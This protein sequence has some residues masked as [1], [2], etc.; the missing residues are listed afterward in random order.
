MMSLK[1]KLTIYIYNKQNK[2]DEERGELNYR[3]RNRPVDD[4]EL[5]EILRDKMR[6]EIWDE[7]VRDLYNI[8]FHSLYDKRWKAFVLSPELD[9]T[10]ILSNSELY[11]N[12][13]YPKR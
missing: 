7:Y 9:K 5:F 11:E 4:L 1:D 10:Y 6:V 2:L 8:V 12:T 3:L 13:A